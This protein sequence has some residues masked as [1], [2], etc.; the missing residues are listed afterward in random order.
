MLIPSGHVVT[1]VSLIEQGLH[2]EKWWSEADPENAAS[3][4]SIDNYGC[5]LGLFLSPLVNRLIFSLSSN[6]P[7]NLQM[8]NK[9][10][11]TPQILLKFWTLHIFRVEY[12]NV[13]FAKNPPLA[14]GKKI[15]LVMTCRSTLRVRL[16]S[17]LVS[18]IER[19]NWWK[20]LVDLVGGTWDWE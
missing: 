1:I 13:L 20:F 4:S 6:T 19:M 17:A 7:L 5:L 8:K 12:R 3:V 15:V 2:T 11:Y 16:F 14:T 18:R 9:A 10:E